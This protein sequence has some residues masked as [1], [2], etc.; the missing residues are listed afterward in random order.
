MKTLAFAS[1]SCPPV[2]EVDA[3]VVVTFAKAAAADQV[4]AAHLLACPACR[5][6]AAMAWALL[7][8]PACATMDAMPHPDLSFLSASSE[9]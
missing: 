4:L 1:A 5:R 3:W 7:P 6:R 2:W 9:P 8:D